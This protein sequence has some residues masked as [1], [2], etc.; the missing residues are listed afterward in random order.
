[1][2]MHKFIWETIKACINET[3][4][5]VTRVGTRGADNPGTEIQTV[6][7]SPASISTG[8]G[9]DAG[10]NDV[11][12]PVEA[13]AA[14]PRSYL[15]SVKSCPTA[16]VVDALVVSGVH[17][18]QHDQ[19]N[20]DPLPANIQANPAN[21]KTSTSRHRPYGPWMLAP[22]RERRQTGRPSGPAPN[23]Q[24]VKGKEPVVPSG[25]RFAPLD[26]TDQP[27]TSG[28]DA[29]DGSD[30]GEGIQ[31]TGP[32]LNATLGGRSR[33]NN[34]IANER[35]IANEPSPGRAVPVQRESGPDHS[36]NRRGTRRAA[37]EDE[38]V[39]HAVDTLVRDGHLSAE[40]HTDPPDGMDDEGDVVMEDEML[41]G[42]GQE[43][44]P[45]GPSV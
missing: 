27:E 34:V 38:H 20:E 1:M 6:M 43:E 15:D 42:D 8:S 39:E 4:Q 19:N 14:Q 28:G 12:S 17:G 30:A 26:P 35:Q 33:R 36:S 44:G 13:G 24:S 2:P 29:N 7:E 40:H 23:G 3:T 31:T 16:S 11:P 25:S 45:D 41:Q 21:G 10:L 22:R 37:E 5:G 18:G 9:K 32:V